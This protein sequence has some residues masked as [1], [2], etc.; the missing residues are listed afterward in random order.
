MCMNDGILI[1]GTRAPGALDWARLSKD[2]GYRVHTVDVTPARLC[3]FSN[4][5]D[6][7]H[8]VSPPCESS[9]CY[10]REL[11]NLCS[12]HNIRY[13]LPTC[14]EIFH[15]AKY[16]HFFSDEVTVLCS[17]FDV[18]HALHDKLAFALSE[19][20]MGIRSPETWLAKDFLERE[21]ESNEWFVKPIYSR[22][23]ARGKKCRGHEEVVTFLQD[24][25]HA[26]W[27]VQKYIEGDEF[28]SYSIAHSASL[29]AHV[30]Y[31]PLVR[32]N[33][34]ASIA[35]ESI[36]NEEVAGW[37]TLLVEELDFFGQIAF[38]FIKDKEG[39]IWVIECNPRMT[40]GIHFF[41]VEHRLLRRLMDGSEDCATVS[42]GRR[43]GLKLLA[44]C[45]DAAMFFSCEDVF[46][47]RHGLR[48]MPSQFFALLYFSF[49]AFRHGC[50]VNE[51]TVRD[52]EW[53]G[54][55]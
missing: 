29:V 46:W 16:K 47:K 31:Q 37:I 43:K 34:G 32:T 20:P 53:N 41:D 19:K 5:V 51:A 12:K 50:S 40:S 49:S 45:K 24:Q 54:G 33:G 17:E 15:I 9:E 38:D 44:A 42:I 14:E 36:I 11:S 10:V 25:D 30:S 27:L 2:A 4:Y 55:E 39:Q 13:V 1:T 3:L 52:I 28:C 35:F 7:S 8:R 22:F 21:H 6:E 18:L 48:I 23:G 26:K